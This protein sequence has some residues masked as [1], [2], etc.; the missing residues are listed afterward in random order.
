ML[1]CVQPLPEGGWVEGDPQ[2]FAEV[3][4]SIKSM[5]SPST[6][7]PDGKGE[8]KEFFEDAHFLHLP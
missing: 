1:L 8:T 2:L 7:P 5:F 6:L 3:F 4:C